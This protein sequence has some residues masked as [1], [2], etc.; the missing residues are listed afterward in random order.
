MSSAKHKKLCFESVTPQLVQSSIT[1][2]S[3]LPLP[4]EG[5]RPARGAAAA[6]RTFWQLPAHCV[7][8]F[9]FYAGKSLCI[10]GSSREA[11]AKTADWVSGRVQQ[12]SS[13]DFEATPVPSP[14]LSLEG[15]PA[16][17]HAGL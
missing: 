6:R 11:T 1:N 2:D 16:R 10:L 3:V 7:D 17:S 14:K 13:H 5:A 15:K 12:G 4:P 8:A 9:T